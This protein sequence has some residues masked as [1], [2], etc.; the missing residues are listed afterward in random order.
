MTDKVPFVHVSVLFGIWYLVNGILL[1]I[2]PWFI[3]LHT[4]QQLDL[5]LNNRLVIRP[6]HG[7][8]IALGDT[9]KAVPERFDKRF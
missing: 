5:R 8:D 4:K 3:E 9:S 6:F 7:F 2:F 1:Y